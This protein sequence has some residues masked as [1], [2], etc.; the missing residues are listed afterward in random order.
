MSL[1][2]FNWDDVTLNSLDDLR[3]CKKCLQDYLQVAGFAVHHGIVQMAIASKL[4]EALVPAEDIPSILKKEH[5]LGQIAGLTL[6]FKMLPGK[7][8]E[9]S[10]AIEVKLQRMQQP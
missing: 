5:V 7:I 4:N 1:S 6:A 9:L 10:Q 2:N 8:D 3:D